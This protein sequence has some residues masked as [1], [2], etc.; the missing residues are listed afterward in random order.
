MILQLTEN[1][2]DWNEKKCKNGSIGFKIRHMITVGLAV[3]TKRLQVFFDIGT[4]TNCKTIF[5]HRQ[6]N[7][8]ED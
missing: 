4:N 7:D 3:S 2:I 1:I 5:Q 6:A 8:F